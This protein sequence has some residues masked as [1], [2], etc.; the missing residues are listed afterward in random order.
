M[1]GGAPVIGLAPMAALAWSRLLAGRAGIFPQRA[2]PE[3]VEIYDVSGET[4]YLMKVVV[5]D[6]ESLN[7]VYKTLLRAAKVADIS[8]A[9]VPIS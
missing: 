7:R 3:I 6:I 5:A 2:H 9:F 8:S 4:D 1:R